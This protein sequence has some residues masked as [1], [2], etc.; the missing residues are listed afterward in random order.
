MRA[1]RI[2]LATA[3]VHRR[4]ERGRGRGRPAKETPCQGTPGSWSVIDGDLSAGIVDE[5]SARIAE[6]LRARDYERA[7]ALLLEAAEAHPQS[8][9]GAAHCWAACSS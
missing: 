4:A 5:R 1:G 2:P 3:I 9:G 6:A 8:V 7:E